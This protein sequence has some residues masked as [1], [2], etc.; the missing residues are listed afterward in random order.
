MNTSQEL[1]P[2]EYLSAFKTFVKKQIGTLLE[3]YYTS[4]KQ[5]QKIFLDSALDFFVEMKQ[6]GTVSS[7]E[8]IYVKILHFLFNDIEVLNEVSNF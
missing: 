2:Q 4:T 5:S 7:I 6:I 3:N 8:N 1:T